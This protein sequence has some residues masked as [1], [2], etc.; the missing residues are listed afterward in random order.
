VPGL[1]GDESTPEDG[2]STGGSTPEAEA[3]VDAGKATY[4]NV[5]EPIL[6]LGWWEEVLAGLAPSGSVRAA[7]GPGDEAGA[8]AALAT[9]AAGVDARTDGPGSKGYAGEDHGEPGASTRVKV[10]AEYAVRTRLDNA[11][12]GLADWANPPWMRVM[13][14]EMSASEGMWASC[15]PCRAAES[16]VRLPENIGTAYGNAGELPETWGDALSGDPDRARAAW[17]RYDENVRV[18]QEIAEGAATVAGAVRVGV[19]GGGLH[20][21]YVR[22]ASKGGT[23][24]LVSGARVVDRRTG[25]VLEGTVDLGPTLERIET[26]GS[27]P[28]RNDGGIFNNRPLP[29]RT[30]PELPAQ[31]AGYYRE[32]VHPTPGVQGPGP[33][34][35]VVGQGGEMY[36]TPDHYQT[37][38][39]LNPG[40]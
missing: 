39:P 13:N 15:A 37:F 1:P 31:P 27:F 9:L 29:G 8:R 17:D 16:V 34:R 30:T 23:T 26:G 36:Y 18:T 7:V 28:H 4:L 2:S 40:G 11:Y 22:V 19:G 35:V 10:L 38:V 12:E 6:V 3:E 24:G 33:Q 20:R 14:G 21:P 5:T 25:T 32:Y